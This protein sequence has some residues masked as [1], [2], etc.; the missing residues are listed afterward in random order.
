V[1]NTSFKAGRARFGCIHH[2]DENETWRKLEQ[3]VQRGS[4]GKE[5]VSKRQ[6]ASSKKPRDC[7]RE[8]Y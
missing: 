2:G 7:S 6:E 5:I 4:E 1:V 3:H 8:K